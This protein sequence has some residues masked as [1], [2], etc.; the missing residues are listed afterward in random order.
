MRIAK[1]FRWEAAHRLPWHEGLCKNLHGHSY[2][3]VV[4]LEG[5]VNARGMLMDFKELKALVA[6]LVNAW[7]HAILVHKE[8]EELMAIAR[9]TGWKSAVLPFD[10][11]CENMCE[12]VAAYLYETQG[13]ALRAAGVVGVSVRIEETET[14]YAETSRH[15]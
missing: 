7:D 8:D 1:R 14:A 4:G 6:P 15:I 11:T 5:D 10:T 2:R 12:H 3:M 13:E 9:S